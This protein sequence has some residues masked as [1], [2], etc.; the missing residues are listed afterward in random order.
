VGVKK[1]ILLIV[2]LLVTSS[3]WAE[4]YT[5]ERVIDCGTLKLTN[6]ERVRLIG[7]DCPESKPND[8][9]KRDAKRTGQDL[10]TINKMGQEATEEL[11]E[12]FKTYGNE[13][14]LK[15]DVQEKDKYGRL[16]AYVFYDSGIT[17]KNLLNYL[18]PA[19]YHFNYYEGKWMCFINA[20]MI[21]AGYAQP[22]TIPPNVKY[23]ELFE[24]LYQEARENKRGLWKNK[25]KYIAKTIGGPPQVPESYSHND[26]DRDGDCDEVDIAVF[27]SFL[28]ECVDGKNYNTLADAN[29]DRCITA[30][31]KDLLFP[32]EDEREN[33]RGLW[34]QDIQN[35]RKQ[36][37][38]PKA[39]KFTKALGLDKEHY[40]MRKLLVRSGMTN[41]PL[42]ELDEISTREDCKNRNGIWGIWGFL[43]MKVCNIRTTDKGKECKDHYGCQG[44]CVTLLTGEQLKEKYEAGNIDSIKMK[45]SEWM[46]SDEYFEPV[47]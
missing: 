40:Q 8:K 38:R 43:N 4:T 9:A 41:V 17:D 34:K 33:K 19:G 15:F 36:E 6:G 44:E 22:M 24:E 28:G 27:N 31:D 2:I 20:T 23:A 13:V 16:L 47:D 1:I 3:V 14:V 10:E 42:P 18:Q 5:V 39:D 30:E 25:E 26:L 7:I 11:K 32:C 37:V 21:K 35:D 12:I 46:F 29:H 45:C